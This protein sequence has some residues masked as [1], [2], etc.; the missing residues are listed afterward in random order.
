MPPPPRC[1][2]PPSRCARGRINKI[3]SRRVRPPSP[4]ARGERRDKGALPLGSER[5]RRVPL[6]L[7]SLATSPARGRGERIKP[8]AD[9]TK[10]FSQRSHAPE[11]C[12]PRR[13][14][15]RFAPSSKREAERRKAHAN[16]VRAAQTS[17]REL[18]PPIRCA[19]A[20]PSPG[21]RPPFGARARGTRHR[22]SPRWLSG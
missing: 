3:A 9:K 21:S 13:R 5:R 15:K 18:A 6:P 8:R 1:R 2:G 11:L 16:H 4:R 7:A 14:Q 10:S 12:Q 22:L 20:R 19:A 17:G